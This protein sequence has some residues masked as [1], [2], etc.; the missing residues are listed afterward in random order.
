MMDGNTPQRPGQGR[1]R[2]WFALPAH[3]L[4]TSGIN[5]WPGT[6]AGP[7]AQT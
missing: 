1:F 6:E 4:P 7:Q 5:G 2:P 3:R